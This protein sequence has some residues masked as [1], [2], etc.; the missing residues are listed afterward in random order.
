MVRP[1]AGLL[2]LFRCA[3]VKRGKSKPLSEEKTSKTADGSGLEVLM[4][5]CWA[6]NAKPNKQ[7]KAKQ[8]MDFID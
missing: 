1:C 5:T 8:T 4:P 6:F 3:V 2:M 7:Q